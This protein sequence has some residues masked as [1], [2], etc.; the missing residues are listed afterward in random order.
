LSLEIA[1]HGAPE[2][3]EEILSLARFKEE[4]NCRFLVVAGCLPQRYRTE[5]AKELP[6]VDLF[7]GTGE[8]GQVV[9][10]LEGGATPDLRPPPYLP[11]GRTPRIRSTPAHWA[12]VKIADGCNHRC[13][14]CVIPDLRGPFRSRPTDD[15][16][17]EVRNLVHSG[18][19][20]VN[21]IA[22]DTTG[23]GKDRHGEE[24]LPELL[25]HLGEVAG[26]E[27]VRFLYAYPTGVTDH[28][29]E[30]MAKV[31]VIAPYIDLPLQHVA[32][33]VLKSMGR[34][35]TA[36]ERHSLVRR[37]RSR[38]PDLALRTTFIVGFPGETE[39]DF[40]QLLHRSD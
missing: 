22:Q 32:A 10:L 11:D 36:E 2:S 20:E 4:G 38:L 3:V 35:Q 33:G 37:M 25:R 21:L 27:L 9:E 24:S 26:L 5:L 19:K 14:Y 15:I 13:T 18:V 34:G 23:Y 6:E 1:G 7:L 39:D 12:Y 40:Q 17:V 28:L 31:P 8:V 16:L 29:L 30:V